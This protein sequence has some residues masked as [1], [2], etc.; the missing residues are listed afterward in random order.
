MEWFSKESVDF[1]TFSII[2][3][4][5]P[6][7]VILRYISVAP[8]G[9]YAN[10]GVF[11]LDIKVPGIIGWVIMESPNIIVPVVFYHH[12]SSTNLGFEV[13][14]YLLGLYFTH[15]LYRYTLISYHICILVE[16]WPRFTIE[17]LV[18]ISGT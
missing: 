3:L 9:R 16:L 17:F 6:I 2:L 8:F 12:L 10:E 5:V 1:V 4:S 18:V 14:R 11:R 13:N 15:Y 7:Y